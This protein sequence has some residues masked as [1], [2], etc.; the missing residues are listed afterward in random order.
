M[1][2]LTSICQMLPSWANRIKWQENCFP[3]ISS[4]VLRF[5]LSTCMVLFSFGNILFPGHYFISCYN[6]NTLE[7]LLTWLA[8]VAHRWDVNSRAVSTLELLSWAC[9]NCWRSEA[10]GFVFFSPLEQ[11]QGEH[12]LWS[13]VHH[14]DSI[15]QKHL[16]LQ[17]IEFIKASL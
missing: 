8:I 17:D 5:L 6:E 14:V 10:I 1:F 12:E 16:P 11:V 4:D 9:D 3:Y 2:N 15:L 13:Q 7:S